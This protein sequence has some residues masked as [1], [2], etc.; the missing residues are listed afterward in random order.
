MI[1]VSDTSPICYLLL[2]GEIEL[3]PQLYGQ[4]L[5]P[6]IVQQELSNARSPVSVQNWS[7]CLP[8]WLVV[9]TLEIPSNNEI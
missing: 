6:R 2:I 5:I 4:V 9:Q 1:V 8:E 3:L 7:N